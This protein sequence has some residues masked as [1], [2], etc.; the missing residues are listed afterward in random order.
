MTARRAL[1]ALL[2]VAWA[3]MAVSMACRLRYGVDVTDEAF[4]SAVP[5]EFSA[6]G[7][8]DARSL[9]GPLLAPLV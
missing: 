6:N 3:G 1:L 2:L 9:W 7:F 5:Y 8:H 4:Y